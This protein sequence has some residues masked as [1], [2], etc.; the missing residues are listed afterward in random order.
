MLILYHF[1]FQTCGI[2]ITQAG[3]MNIFHKQKYTD[4]SAIVKKVKIVVNI[5]K[6]EFRND[7]LKYIF[8][9]AYTACSIHSALLIVNN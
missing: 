6:T 9:V 1:F 8:I 5:N 3:H 4:L 2:F 7:V